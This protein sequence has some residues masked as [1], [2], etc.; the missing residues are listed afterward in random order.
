MLGDFL[1]RGN[2]YFYV[3]EFNNIY[4]WSA[5][6]KLTLNENIT[7]RMSIRSSNRF[8]QT[9]LPTDIENKQRIKQ[10]PRRL[11]FIGPQM[12]HRHQLHPQQMLLALLRYPSVKTSPR[13]R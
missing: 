11:D 10:A 2:L 9:T 6:A 1:F 3:A 12:G 13:Q 8:A 7:L 5:A 4:S